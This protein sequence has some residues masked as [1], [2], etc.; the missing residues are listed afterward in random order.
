MN[1]MK[2]LG[3]PT[4]ASYIMVGAL[5]LIWGNTFLLVKF[6]LEEASPILVASARILI[7]A[8]AIIPFAILT[9][10]E[11][12]RGPLRW[13]GAGAIGTF[14]LAIPMSLLAWAQQVVPSGVAG[15]YMAVIPLM[16]LPLAHV[17]SPGE[18]MTRNRVAG[19]MIG[20]AGVL[21]LLGWET[22]TAI[23]SADGLAQLAC[24]GAAASYAIG[25][26][27]TRRT[28]PTDPIAL[29]AA[30]FAFGAFL[31]LPYTIRDW[32]QEGLSGTTWLIFLFLGIVSSG[33][34]MIL[35]TTIITTVGSVF[36]SGV[37]YLVPITAL[38]VGVIFAGEVLAWSDLLACALILGG[39][40][41]AS[42]R[43]GSARKTR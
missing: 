40:A 23:G 24:L 34:A 37:G 33:L 14:T 2:T 21:T 5:V 16:V 3:A 43:Q 36:M 26:I 1:D 17:F 6:A 35:R 31:I 9:K 12:L 4:P 29:S 20:F 7:G 30:G 8:M 28:P 32:P 22:L 42:R 19:F 27:M 41:I 39:L 15:V 11:R 38:T 13:I 18:P 10:R 25:S